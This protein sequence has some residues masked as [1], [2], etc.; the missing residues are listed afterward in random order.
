[1]PARRP[2]RLAPVMSLVMLASTNVRAEGAASG[3]ASAPSAQ[4]YAI[5]IANKATARTLQL[6]LDGARARLSTSECQRVLDDFTDGAGHHLRER[7]GAAGQ[8]PEGYLSLIVFYDGQA[9]LRCRSRDTLALA[10]VG[11]RVVYVCP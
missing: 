9:N 5:H 4:A 8:S 11:S 10:A 1:M 3:Q 6:V 2:L 7:V